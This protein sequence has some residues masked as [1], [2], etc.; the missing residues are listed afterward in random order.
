MKII[1]NIGQEQK[2]INFSDV[3]HKEQEK[4][5]TITA[6]GQTVVRPDSG[7]TLSKVTVNTNVPIPPQTELYE[8]QETIESNG[9]YDFSPAE[10][11]GFSGIHIEV[12]VQESHDRNEVIVPLSNGTYDSGTITWY[13]GNGAL[14]L[15]QTQ[16]TGSTSVSGS[17]VNQPRMY[18]GH[19]LK[20]EGLDSAK[21]FSIQM[22]YSGNYFGNTVTAGT[23]LDGDGSVVDNPIVVTRTLSTT[24]NGTHVFGVE[25]GASLIYIQNCATTTNVQLRPTEIVITY[26]G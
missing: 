15:T 20:I 14:R 19:I 3:L 11:K 18:K 2:E 7:Y 4:T 22:K 13:A 26:E 24:S 1:L 6:N 9:S 25:T 16:G 5:V 12:N 23:T 21:I 8:L 17:Y 10:G